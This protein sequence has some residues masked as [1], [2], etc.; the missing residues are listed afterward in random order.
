MS[1]S[2]FRV[3]VNR[4]YDNKVEIQ[5]KIIDN[6]QE[7]FFSDET[8]AMKLLWDPNQP[9]YTPHMEIGKSLTAADMLKPDYIL[10]NYD[11]FISDVKIRD[12]MDYPASVPEKEQDENQVR[13]WW[14][15]QGNLPQSV[16]LIEVTDPGLL[17]HLYEGM[18]WETDAYSL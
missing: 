11:K 17:E 15:Q 8:F 2:I 14:A 5:M 1:V 13:A 3:R 16:L 12:F 4:I 18:E 9:N 7:L 6:N 10:K